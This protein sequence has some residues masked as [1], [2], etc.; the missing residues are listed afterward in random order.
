MGHIP[1]SGQYP[2]MDSPITAAIL[3]AK[4]E[5]LTAQV[6]SLKTQVERQSGE[7]KDL[8]LDNLSRENKALRDA[9]AGQTMQEELRI[10]EAEKSSKDAQIEQ[11]QDRLDEKEKLLGQS[12][13]LLSIVFDESKKGT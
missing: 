6:E 8:Q 2:G 9:L 1:I 3:L 12:F 13:Q 4:V 5:A 11:I 10:A 7:I